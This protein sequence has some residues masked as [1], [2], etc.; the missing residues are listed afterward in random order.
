M[1]A[2]QRKTPAM[3]AAPF[4]AHAP[5]GASWRGWALGFLMM[6]LAAFSGRP[7]GLVTIE[8]RVP[9]VEGLAIS[10]TKPPYP[11]VLGSAVTD[12]EGKYLITFNESQPYGGPITYSVNPQAGAGVTI[13]PASQ[14]VNVSYAGNLGGHGEANFTGSLHISGK[15]TA[16]P[17]ALVRLDLEI[18]VSP[19]SIDQIGS[20]ESSRILTQRF[21]VD[22]ASIT[23]YGTTTGPLYP[24]GPTDRFGL[25][26]MAT[27]RPSVNGR[28]TFF[29]GSDDGSRLLMTDSNGNEV[30]NMVNDGVQSFDVLAREVNLSTD[31]TYNL[32][33]WHFDARGEAGLTLFCMAL[34]GP[35]LPLEPE[36]GWFVTFFDLSRIRAQTFVDS[37]GNYSISR[38]FSS[39]SGAVTLPLSGVTVR[40]VF[41]GYTFDPASHAANA[42]GNNY[43]FV[44]TRSP[45]LFTPAAI[46]PQVTDEETPKTVTFNVSDIQTPAILLEV[47]ASSGNH[48]IVGPGDIQLGGSGTTRSVTLHPRPNATGTNVIT[49]VVR[50]GHG[51]T[52]TNSFHFIVNNVNDPPIA[53][54]KHALEFDG[55]NDRVEAPALA[56]NETSFTVEAWIRRDEANR[57]DLALWQGRG[58]ANEGLQFGFRDNNRFT[59]AF[60]GNDLD[61]TPNIN[62][63]EWHH[64]AGTYDLANNIRSIYLDGQLVAQDQPSSP[65]KGVDAFYLG[66]WP[67][68]GLFFKG[69]LDEVRVWSKA[70]TQAEIATKRFEPLVGNETDLIAY[71]RLDEAGTIHAR[72]S[73]NNGKVGKLTYPDGPVWIASAPGFGDLLIPEDSPGTPVFLPGFDV[74]TPAEDLRYQIVGVSTGSV[75]VAVGTFFPGNSDSNPIGYTPPPEYVGPATITYA[76][77]DGQYT[78]T[79]TINLQI[80]ELNDP[81]LISVIPDQVVL[82]DGV[83]GPVEFTVTDPDDPATNIIVSASSGDVTL[84]PESG[85]VLG[86]AGTN[87][88]LTITPAPGESGTAEIILTAYD[89]YLSSERRFNLRVEARPVYKIFDIGALPNRNVAFGAAINDAGAVLADAA[90][91][92]QGQSR[93]A[94]I[95]SGLESG[96]SITE[97]GTLADTTSSGAALN[98]L[99]EV[100]G[101][102]ATADGLSRAF[103]RSY[104]S[105][106]QLKDLG[107]L[108]GGNETFG[109]GLNDQGFAVG[110]GTIAGGQYRGFM[111]TNGPTLRE[112][113]PLTPGFSESRAFGINISNLVVGA[114]YAGTNVQATLW[115][116]DETQGLGFL[117]GGSYSVAH[118]INRFGRVVGVANTTVGSITVNRA[119]MW[120]GGELIDLGTLP[121]GV[122]SEALGV[123]NFGQIVGSAT[124]SNEVRAI[125]FSAGQTYD[126]NEIVPEEDRLAWRLQRAH[127]INT[128]GEIVGS[129]TYHGVPRA[130]V[131]IPAN[132]IGRKVTRP[133]GTVA[134]VPPQIEL[135]TPSGDDTAGNSFHFSAA[136][137]KLYAIR[138]VVARVKWPTSTNPLDTNA[139]P[140]SVLNVNVWPRNPQTHIAGAPVEVEPAVSGF[141]YSFQ[142]LLY[143]TSMGANV[144]G[145]SKVFNT[146]NRGYSVLYYLRNQGQPVNP[147][148]QHPY[149]EVARTYLWNDP[150]VLPPSMDNVVTTIGQPVTSPLHRDHPGRNG[151]THFE[152]SF[153]DGAGPERAYDRATRTGTI[154]PVNRDKP[155]S[156]DDFVVVWYATNSIN[157]SWAYQPVR[158]TPVWPAD[159]PEIVIAST[160]GSGELPRSVYGGTLR[161]YNQPDPSLPGFNPNEEHALLAPANGG[162][163]TALFA[164]RNDLNRFNGHSEPYALLKYR[165]PV[166]Q[167][168]RIQ[169]FRV[170]AENEVYRFSYD[171]VAG[172]E[173]APPYPMSLL[174]LMPESHG[175]SGPYWEDYN[176]K[177]YAR[178]AGYDLNLTADIVVRWWY[179]LQPGFFY[180]L[181]GDGQQD[182]P[183]GAPMGLLERRQENNPAQLPVDVNYHIR[184]PISPV[185]QIGETLTRPKRGLPDIFN[186]A[187]AEIIWDSSNPTI[188]LTGTNL[189]RS[190]VRLFDP[191]GERT[192]RVADVPGLSTP[193]QQFEIPPDIKTSMRNGRIR[194]DDLPPDIYERLS[195][196]PLNK[197]FIFSGVFDELRTAG[198]P[199]YLLN[200]LT[201][202]ERERIKD[203]DGATGS[204]TDWDKIFDALYDL[205]RN[206]NK[207]DLSP[208]DG[209]P[210]RDLR[211]GF[212]QDP[213]T[214][215]VYLEQLPEMKALT[216]AIG[217]APQPEPQ[218][219]NALLFDGVDDFV[220]A[221]ASVDLTGV[222][223][224]IEFWAARSASGGP[225]TIISL[226]TP[227][228]F[229][230]VEA[231]FLSDNRFAFSFGE[232]APNLP[233]VTSQAYSETGWHHWAVS[234]DA[235]TG[236]RTIFR[237]GIAVAGDVSAAPVAPSGPLVIGR[238]FA[239]NHFNGRLDD[240]RV[241]NL[242]RTPF[243]IAKDFPKRLIGNEEG[244]LRYFRFDE[245]SGNSARDDGAAGLPATISGA[246]REVSNAPT[247]IPPRFV[248][249]AENSDPELKLPVSLHVIRIDDGPYVG[250]LNDIAP[251][252]VFS[253]RISIRHSGDFG[254]EPELYRFEWWYRPDA[255][256]VDPTELPV[257]DPV[258]GNVIDPRGWLFFETSSVEGRGVNYITL[259]DGGQ[260]SLLT[261]G[262]NWFIMRYRKFESEENQGPWSD[263]A[264]DPSG[265]AVPRA[266]LV[267]GWIKRVIRGLNPFDQRVADFHQN[268]VNTFASMLIQAGRRYEGDIAFNPDADAINSIGLIEAYETVLRRGKRLSI[269]G[270][271]AVNFDAANNALLLIA[272]RIADLYVLLG[273]EA[274]AD[275]SDPTIGFGTGQGEYGT[276]STSIFAFQNQLDSLL[277]EELVLLRGRDDR[278]AGVG[279]PP[280]YNRLFWN[281]TLGDGEVAYQQAYNINDFNN[282]GFIDELDARIMYPQGH[283]DAWGHYLTAIKT[284]YGLLR[285][286]NFTWT[287]RAENVLVN[288]VAVQ[289]D[290][291]DERKFARTAAAR[292][293]TGA[294]VLNLTYRLNY[295]DDPDGQWQGYEDPDKDRAWGVTE[296]A[297]RAGQAAIFDWITAN[298]ILPSVDPNPDHSGIT[299]IDRQT[300]SELGEIAGLV[301]EMQARLD[302]SDVGLNPLGVAKG[303][304]PFDVDPALFESGYGFGGA[305]H[306]EQIQERAMRA[307]NNAVKV[308]DE[309]NKFTSLLRRN[310]DD[311]DKFIPEVRS[312]ELVYRNEL[313]EIFG[314]PYAGDI[315]PGRT[316][317]SGYDGPDL[318]HYMYVDTAEITGEAFPPAGE[319]KGFFKPLED[320]PNH[321]VFF[322]GSDRVY[323]VNT[324]ET[325]VLEVSYPQVA[326]GYTFAAPAHWGQRRAPGELQEAL[327]DIVQE[328]ARLKQALQD[329]DGLIRDIEDALEILEAQKGVNQEEIEVI[330]SKLAVITTLNFTIATLKA[331]QIGL[332]RAAEEID[333]GFEGQI[334]GLPKVAGLAY[335]TTAPARLTLSQVSS[336][337]QTG[338]NIG[339]DVAEAAENF[340]EAS[341][342]TVELATDLHLAIVSGDFEVLQKVKEIEALFREEAAR[343]LEVY[344]QREALMQAMGRYRAALARGERVLQELVLFRK[345]AAADTAEQRYED[346]T[347]RIFRNDALQKYRAAFDFAARMVYLSAT[348]FDYEVNF[349]GSDPRS[350]SDFLTDIIRQ[351][352]LGQVIDGEP[353][354][355]I[356]GL[357]DPLARLRANHEVLK[358][359]FGLSNPQYQDSRFSLR[360]ELYRISGGEEDD[361]VWREQLQRAR[362]D[363]LWDIPEFRRY[364]R[365]FALESAGPQPA[366]VFRFPTTVT[367]GLNFF[368]WP[369]GPGDSAYDPTLFS[370]KISRVGVWFEG[371]NAELVSQTPRVYLVPVGMDILRSPTGNDLATREWRV[372]DQVVPVPFPIGAS[373]LSD[374]NW[375]PARDALNGNFVQIR[376]YASFRAYQDS[377]IYNEAETT[378]DTR[379][380]GRSVWNTEWM[381]IIPG[382]TLLANPSAGLEAFIENVTDIR[383][384][385][386]T[387][388]YSGN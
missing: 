147:Q 238:G 57:W 75:S 206:P 196:D 383:L 220:N 185:L 323:D 76:L 240:V 309:A 372:L 38:T 307:L 72:D 110:Y 14:Q 95:Y 136:S 257:V 244:L 355:G 312:Q 129:G 295:V 117:P 260:S 217:D 31:M 241:W 201:E 85:I 6:T 20:A 62:V 146:S 93:R 54:S 338:L 179:P 50:D 190:A 193:A 299:R 325:S 121:G 200:I 94:F 342:D 58:V 119:F 65:F 256:E 234:Y 237:D 315:G 144:D 125:L 13:S 232:S 335:D 131:A 56:L 327:S 40:P 100:V 266:K 106:F 243:S 251:P 375:S 254:A 359:Q 329:Y 59:F 118:A 386:Q 101:S 362:V 37:A 174:T 134:G 9:G 135:L 328:H 296:W 122:S 96:G 341:K 176:N 81:P 364:C 184:W 63:G 150:A 103:I 162:A 53:G 261:L 210:D 304:V 321:H 280:V 36:D 246:A 195:Y 168:W 127:G 45:P 326:G 60:W 248:T 222:S 178:A 132:T 194:F 230:G 219:G 303:A 298:A 348:A 360:R 379:L 17:G 292:A 370:T 141:E 322:P 11:G 8:G 88:T 330:G 148:T 290:F 281:F 208:A 25:R 308:W 138:P 15:V 311:I 204:A 199:F 305:T 107:V 339:A 64:W 367:F 29:L 282:D 126:L 130:F 172:N 340:I 97:V 345:R 288:G 228:P 259:G 99:N 183:P 212:A 34:N 164:L 352:A 149:F 262:D 83:L 332:R 166:A 49:L 343:R 151:W 113:A 273:N 286:P 159:A 163:G 104:A 218:P 79:H 356:R 350:A 27:W 47:T 264:G 252:N 310:Q 346:M 90:Q 77:T 263:W 382:G 32:T 301:R 388:S 112:L 44:V 42:S 211:V 215:E 73:S 158:Y 18:P 91:N 108:V 152:T 67:A 120:E 109:T 207:V 271:P 153:Y 182:A 46:Q 371:E 19:V 161:V 157:V 71:W 16:P 177:I 82:E 324:V 363:N 274:F 28:H 277:E 300:V 43:N 278:S 22:L 349:L 23:G 235:A 114:S 380:I 227:S 143:T 30:L 253:E 245:E 192:L 255:G 5:A 124:V 68:R 169:P 80:L 374:P 128:R 69:A 283:G 378:T 52:A 358:P 318:Y 284:W 297:R 247:G 306:F 139:V 319:F 214:R 145:S 1:N 33:V 223:F 89:G 376:R 267:E 337:L 216:A 170:I 48:E 92:A 7:A 239:G 181:D 314:Y 102:S 116:A 365:P 39:G 180:D 236:Q 3:A 35:P 272:S 353:V 224:T 197:W 171:G 226:G 175:V 387:F 98:F 26:A 188:D 249:I 336:G 373:S 268:E 86:G 225:Q 4:H 133:A 294:E 385:F 270:T 289:V 155:T 313:I 291:L 221:G 331:T 354:V 287:P 209:I 198:E 191:V 167:D 203:L 2:A 186:F 111:Y 21:N 285:H 317:P 87:R 10:V 242:P 316:Y 369:L 213:V 344:N 70:R 275:A 293:K 51:M 189:L 368:G 384:F 377:G 250:Q 140:V 160:F 205:T 258:S 165:D 137:G 351:R 173:I 78:N 202:R 229:A 361:D 233:L 105:N 187:S 334:E 333:K 269:D 61:Y 302:E 347:F 84:I 231:G 55:V 154:L 265:G 115:S 276:A 320:G 12:A 66:Y 41:E 357:A 123:N 381:L 74:D 279:A 142:S 366:L 24:G 156:Q